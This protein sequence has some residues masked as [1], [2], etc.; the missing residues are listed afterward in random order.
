M[1]KTSYRSTVGDC[2]IGVTGLDGAS[3]PSLEFKGKTTRSFDDDDQKN[4]QALAHAVAA[5]VLEIVKES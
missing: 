3:H 2:Q 4:G 1:A 5:G